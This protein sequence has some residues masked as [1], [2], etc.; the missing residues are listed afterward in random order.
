MIKQI[1][2]KKELLISADAEKKLQE[3]ERLLLEY[4]ALFNLTSITDHDEIWA[5]LFLDSASGAFLF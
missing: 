1:D 2:V 4:N 3:F 5:K